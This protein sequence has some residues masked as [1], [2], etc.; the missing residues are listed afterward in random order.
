MLK[1]KQETTDDKLEEGLVSRKRGVM[2]LRGEDIHE[3]AANFVRTTMSPPNAVNF[4]D[5][6]F[7]DFENDY[8]DK[9]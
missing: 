7:E 6:C 3:K 5:K 9:K 8:R 2:L 1:R 4:E